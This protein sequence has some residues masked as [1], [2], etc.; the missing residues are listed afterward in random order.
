MVK[1][2]LIAGWSVRYPCIGTNYQYEAT[3]SVRPEAR[4]RF[5]HLGDA[6]R[7]C[8]KND[9]SREAMALALKEG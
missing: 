5:A 1:G 7:W 4:M 8:E 3:S 2:R 6:Q 9:V